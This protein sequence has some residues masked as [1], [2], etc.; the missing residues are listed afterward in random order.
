MKK[1]QT[2]LIIKERVNRV[3][4]ILDLS[5]KE[6]ELLLTPKRIVKHKLTVDGEAIPAWR[7]LYNDALGPGKGGIRFHPD[8]SEDEVESLAFW[9]TLKNS[10]VGLPYGG[11]KGGVKFNPKGKSPEYLEKV[12][13]AYMNYFYKFVG[14]DIDIPAPD[15]YTNGAIM[16]WMLDAYEKKIGHH[17]PG[18]ITGKPIELGGLK[19]RGDATAKGG[20]I[21]LNEVIH[22]DGVGKNP[23]I[24]IQGFGNAGYNIAKMLYADGFKVIAVSDSR[25]GVYDQSGLDINRV[26]ETKKESGSVTAYPAKV[27]TNDEL[28]ELKV[29]ILILAALENQITIKNADKVQARYI[30]ELANGPVDYDAD[31]I[32]NK[33]GITVVPDI[34]AN[35]GGVIVSYF[36]WAQNRTGNILDDDYLAQKLFNMLESSWHQVYELYRDRKDIDLRTS[37]YI[38]AIKRVLSAEKLRGNL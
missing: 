34:L 18:M 17:E 8:A 38:I 14:Q 12:S 11:A 28:L 21:I 22:H 5:K 35:S 10:L 1:D 2:F 15:V 29:D 27:I 25:G 16:A 3:G 31:K 37:A 13:R 23:T 26:V 24:A 33:R 30:I 7:I 36:E 6:I 4:E 20:H 32:L 9:M 19:M